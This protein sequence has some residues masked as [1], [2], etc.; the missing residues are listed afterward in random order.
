MHTDSSASRTCFRSRSARE[1]TATVRIPNSRHARRMRRA[2]SPRL[3]MMTLVSI[4]S[5]PLS[6]RPAAGFLE[7]ASQT[8]LV[9]LGST[10][11][12]VHASVS[13]TNSGSPYSTGWP[14][15]AMI[16]F[17]SPSTSDSIWLRIFIASMMHNVSPGV[18]R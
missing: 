11:R 1:C 10:R 18:T 4:G 13:M 2:I 5:R 12:G 15:S 7:T 8:I 9:E 3:A 17:T 16:A 14:F 6:G